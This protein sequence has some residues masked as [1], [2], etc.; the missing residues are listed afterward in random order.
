[1]VQARMVDG[2]QTA[3]GEQGLHAIFETVF[4][5]G[6]LYALELLAPARRGVGFDQHRIE[7]RL[8]A[9][10]RADFMR[11]VNG[12][13]GT[14]LCDFLAADFCDALLMYRIDM[15]EDSHDANGIHLVCDQL[16]G[17]R[18]RLVLVKWQDDVAEMVDA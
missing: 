2:G 18:A 16:P 7:P 3:K 8:L 10:D 17:C 4:F 9:N 12:D 14:G 5:R 1:F 6:F 13:V 11:G 15:G